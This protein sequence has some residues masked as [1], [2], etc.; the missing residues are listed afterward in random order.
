MTNTPVPVR[1]RR[2]WWWALWAF[3]AVSAVGFGLTSPGALVIGGEDASLIPIDPDVAAHFL[4]LVVHGVPGGLALL[5]GPFQFV[6]ALRVRYPVAHRTMGRIYLVAV[7][8]AAV[9]ALYAATV[10]LSG[11]SIQVAF[12]LLAAAW[13]FTA[14]QAYRTIRRG[15]VQLHRIWMIRNYALT[16]AAVSLRIFLLTGTA[17]MPSFP[18]LEFEAVYDASG[19]ASIVVNVMVAEYFIVQRT[20]APLVRRGQR[21]EAAALTAPSS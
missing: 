8:V 15:D 3:L 20:L 14:A 1:H 7:V 5:L 2:R 18:E 6:T 19:W 9:A 4:S 13:L 17:L 16:F 12:Y 11:F 10:S 21:R